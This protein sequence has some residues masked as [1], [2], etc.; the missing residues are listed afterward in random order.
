VFRKL[1]FPYPEH[2]KIPEHISVFRDGQFFYPRYHP[3]WQTEI[4]DKI[5]IRFAL[6]FT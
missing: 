1:E 2:K 6:S 5:Y 4:S 3:H